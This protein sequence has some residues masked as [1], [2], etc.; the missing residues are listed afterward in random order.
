M[1]DPYGG[2]GRPPRPARRSSRWVRVGP[3][4]AFAVLV[5]VLVASYVVD[6][7]P[8]SADSLLR[9]DRSTGRV[10]P[11]SALAGEWSGEGAL[12]DCAGF[13][14]DGCPEARSV[15]FSVDCADEPCVVTPFDRSYGRPPLRFEDG[16]YRAAGP[17]PE[18]AAPICGGAPTTSGLWRLEL[19]VE[20]GRLRGSYAE[21]TVQ[22]FDCGATWLRWEATFD[23]G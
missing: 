23:R 20:E 13:D 12:S 4:L 22:G 14:D 11:P 18:E 17:L 19:T 7:G 6:D 1:T 15:T 16:S 5:A 2:P 9:A 8:G 3:A 21:S 10:V